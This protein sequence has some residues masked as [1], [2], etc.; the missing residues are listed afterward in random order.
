M[1]VKRAGCLNLDD[2][3]AENQ[4]TNAAIIVRTNMMA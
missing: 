4:P 1:N 2:P 3:H